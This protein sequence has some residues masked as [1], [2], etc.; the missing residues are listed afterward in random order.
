MAG[1]AIA[2]ITRRGSCGVSRCDSLDRP[3]S[4]QPRS[5]RPSSAVR[6]SSRP[7]PSNGRPRPGRPTRRTWSGSS[8]SRA[9]SARSSRRAAERRARVGSGARAR[10]SCT[11]WTLATTSTS[12]SRTG[13][14]AGAGR[15]TRSPR[16]RAALA[17]ERSDA[18]RAPSRWLAP[19]V[20][21]GAALLAALDAPLLLFW[22]F[23]RHRRRL[24]LRH[25]ERINLLAVQART[26]TLTRLGNRRAFEDDLKAAIARRGESGVGFAL[27]AIDLD[28]LKRINDANGHPAG[29][30]HI[31][32]VA[33]CIKSVVGDVGAVYR[34]GGDE[35]MV[36]LPGLRNWHAQNV[37]TKIDQ[38]TR[39]QTGGRAV[40]IGLTESVGGARR[41]LLVNQVD[42]A[43]YE[44]KRTRL[45]AV[46]FH[47]G[48]RPT[49]L[50]LEED[51]PS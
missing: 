46:A 39:A 10:C 6:G 16:S 19:S 4:R 41:H 18:A 1:S 9:A 51:R 40:S 13:R 50:D 38:L 45:S 14:R 34:T 25:Q 15:R 21:G 3:P 24:E 27:M 7:P 43:L 49:G 17:R 29:D 31:Q 11:R 12:C 32:N 35:F 20:G 47:P 5:R 2:A 36:I 44:A 28:G 37:A 48:L 22:V 8:P 26:D 42:I 23:R 33:S 30:A